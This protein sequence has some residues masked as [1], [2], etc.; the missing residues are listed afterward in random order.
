VT[1]GLRANRE[2]PPWDGRSDICAAWGGWVHRRGRALPGLPLLLVGEARVADRGERPFC[3]LPGLYND[4][5]H[6]SLRFATTSGGACADRFRTAGVGRGD[7]TYLTIVG[8]TR[9]VARW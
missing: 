6:A 1:P 3:G 8:D 5:V 2:P 4:V 9:V 7:A